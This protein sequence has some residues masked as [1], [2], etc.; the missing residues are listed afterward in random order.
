M[1]TKL[2]MLFGGFLL[3]QVFVCPFTYIH[4]HLQ[5]RF[6][7]NRVFFFNHCFPYSICIQR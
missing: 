2:N 6:V 7:K 5:T 3:H 1:N 4:K